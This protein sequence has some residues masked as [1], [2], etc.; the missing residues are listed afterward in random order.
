ME[1]KSKIVFTIVLA[2]F[3]FVL[4]FAFFGSSV[5]SEGTNIDYENERQVVS[6][7][8]LHISVQVDKNN[9]AEVTETFS[10]TFNESGLTEMIRFVPYASYV[11]RS[12]DGKTYKEISYSRIK[13]FSGRA[14]GGQKFQIFVDEQPGFLTL[15]FKENTGYR[16]GQ[17]ARF[18]ISYDLEM[19][20]DKCVGFD[21]VYLNL[22]G[23]ST[24]ATIENV[25]FDV[26]LPQEVNQENL[27]VYHGKKGETKTL[28][29]DSSENLVTGRIDLLKPGEGI[30][31]R[32]VYEDG[33]LN[34][35]IEVN[36]LQFVCLGFAILSVVFAL[37]CLL[38][39]SQ[40]R[41]YPIPVEISAFEGLTPFGAEYFSKGKC[42]EK[43][44]SASIIY[45]ANR[46]YIKVVETDKKEMVLE[47]T[48]KEIDESEDVGARALLNALFKGN[49]EKVE[50]S[51]LSFD[52]AE[53][54]NAVKISE[55][56]KQ[57]AKLYDQKANVKYQ[58]FKILSIAFAL[59]CAIVFFNLPNTFFGFSTNLF[60]LYYIFISAILVLGLILCFSKKDWAFKIVFAILMLFSLLWLYLKI[61]FA[62]FDNCYLGFISLILISSLPFVLC[63][64]KRYSKSGEVLKGRVLGF[65]KYIKM[66]E[67]SQI[68]MFAEVN[69][70]YYFDVLPY[71]YVFDL[72]DVWMSKFK[73]LEITPPSWF[74]SYDPTI[75]DVLVFNS[76]CRNLSASYN[77]SFYA[78]KMKSFEK[79]SGGSWN[80]GGGHHG[81]GSFGGFGGGGFSGGG[82]GGGGFGAR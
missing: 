78:S 65:K 75:V 71:A 58:T 3:F 59:I 26:T 15:S 22:V 64:E 35:T 67:V 79:F 31:L 17:T 21:D 29:F 39:Y 76:L 81:G 13:N 43:S 53:S 8:D 45:L 46:G 7:S 73:D 61:G 69:P 80:S 20:N 82:H 55:N 6:L 34:K 37:V 14:D 50:T 48:T 1:K 30:T 47:R 51:K 28:D 49:K 52:F 4:G 33:F 12:K 77:K 72:S 57:N 18:S 10:V 70:T 36:A 74:V 40:R 11:Y 42:T 63:H 9:R 41:K 19:G 56:H 66:C 5:V 68:K 32:A 62:Q 44:I 60:N 24:L 38:V 16:E 23:T 27:T 54:A 2:L 25:S